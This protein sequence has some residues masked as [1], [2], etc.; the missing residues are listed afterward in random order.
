M[1]SF[2]LIQSFQVCYF[3]CFFLQLSI[4]PCYLLYVAPFFLFFLYINFVLNCFL[5]QERDS[6]RR[7]VGDLMATCEYQEARMEGKE[8]KEGERN[9][10]RR[11]LR[12]KN[13]D[14]VRKRAEEEIKNVS[15]TS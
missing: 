9:W 1:F 7:Q 2:C 3:S 4:S 10:D 8:A 11:S 5:I 15:V 12:R 14:K 6:Y 13:K